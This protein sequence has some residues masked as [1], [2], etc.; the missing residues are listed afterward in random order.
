MNKKLHVLVIPSWYP[1]NKDDFKGS[2][3]REQS[4][5]V[6]KHGC[7]VGVIFPDLKSLRGLKKVRLFPKI[8]FENDEGMRTFRMLWNNWFP[9]MR[10]LQILFFKILGLILFKRYV[11]EFG[12]P[13][14]IHCHSVMMGGWLT[15]KI[16]DKYKIPFVITEHSSG[17][18][19]GV[20][21]KYYTEFKRIFKK[22]SISFGV[23]KPLCEL[24]YCEVTN[25][26]KFHPHY[27]IVNSSFLETKIS[28]KNKEPFVFLSIS[29]LIQHKNIPLILKSFKRFNEKHSNSKLNI[30]GQGVER[31]NLIKLS[32]KLNISEKVSFLGKKTRDQIVQELNK[33]NV[34]VLGTKYETFGV[35][36]I[37][38]LSMGV[39][40]IVTDCG[41]SYDIMNNE[42]GRVTK[43]ND[44]EDMYNSM[45]DV[46]NKYDEFK[47]QNLRDYSNSKFSEEKLSNTLIKHYEK[48]LTKS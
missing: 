22:S 8:H 38:S 32:K 47:P 24:L 17:F 29:N 39:P 19:N 18:F 10:P 13:D 12:K 45:I 11:K 33:S 26:K 41:G 14:I 5:G 9:K 43:Q 4:L 15:E 42:V 23:S 6:L 1:D 40:V 36:L 30:V 35:V 21:E 2:F 34:F 7:D 25:S 3:F 27:N 48:I 31:N 16:S 20:F 37:E 46:Y 44:I 28:K